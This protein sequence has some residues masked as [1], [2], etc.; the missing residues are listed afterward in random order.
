MTAAIPATPEKIKPKMTISH[1][2]IFLGLTGAGDVSLFSIAISTGG[3]AILPK[4]IPSF[5][6]ITAITM[7]MEEEKARFAI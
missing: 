2:L 1:L 3:L 6:E 7:P 4:N 5:R